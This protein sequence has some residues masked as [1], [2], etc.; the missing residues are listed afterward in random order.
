MTGC[1]KNVGLTS[2]VIIALVISTAVIGGSR[3]QYLAAAGPTPLRF[4]LEV[5]RLDPAKALPP[6]GMGERPAPLANTNAEPVAV[7]EPPVTNDEGVETMLEP[8]K[9][10]ES[11]ANSGA[12]ANLR[13][14]TQGWPDQNAGYESG[15]SMVAPQMLLRYFQGGTNEVLVPFS[16]DFTPPVR[17]ERRESSAIYKSE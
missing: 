12:V 5:P 7:A 8:V 4:R 16:V 6:L 10:I 13:P 14:E 17:T 9:T 15:S 3:D 1:F 2:S 11:E